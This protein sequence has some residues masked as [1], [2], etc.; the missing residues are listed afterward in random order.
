MFD[1]LYADTEKFTYWIDNYKGKFINI[2]TPNGGT[3]SESENLITCLDGWNISFKLIENDDFSSDS[4]K[5]QRVIF[6]K[7]NLD[8]NE[9]LH[10]KNQFQKFLESSL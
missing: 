3:K 1:G 6:I 10:T 7:S 9:V 5:N 2:Y 4:L 8:H